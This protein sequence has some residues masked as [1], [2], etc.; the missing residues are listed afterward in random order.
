MAD[1][2]ERLPLARVVH[3]HGVGDGPLGVLDDA[4]MC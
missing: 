1:Q 3:R 4:G 2:L